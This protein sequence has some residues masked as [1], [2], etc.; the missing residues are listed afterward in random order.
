MGAPLSASDDVLQIA[1]RRIYQQA[2]AIRLV[3]D[4]LD[5]EFLAIARAILAGTGKVFVGGS[6]TSGTIARRMAHVLSVSGTPSLFFSPVDATH[7]AS[8]AI[9]STDIVI[10]ISNGGASTEVVQSAEIAKGLGATVVAIT[11]VPESPLGEVAD[12][13]GVVS[14]APEAE[15]GGVIATGSTLAQ[16]AW[17]DALA[18]ILMRSK[19]YTWDQFMHS[20]PSG[21]VGARESLPPDFEILNL[22]SGS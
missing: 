16:A 14:V 11:A 18:E 17:G 9:E 22:G 13:V 20:H 6:G 1:S 21:A 4:N 3:A 15:I 19:G 10:L 5:D 7:G 8:A 2:D 12:Y